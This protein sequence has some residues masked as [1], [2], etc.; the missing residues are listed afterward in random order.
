MISLSIVLF[1]AVVDSEFNIE[2]G[3]LFA[4]VQVLVLMDGLSGNSYFFNST[5]II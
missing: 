2:N 5:F 1:D 3:L 4:E